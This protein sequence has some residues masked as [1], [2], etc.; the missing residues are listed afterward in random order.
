[1]KGTLKALVLFS[2][3][4]W[5]NCVTWCS[6]YLNKLFQQFYLLDIK[7][8]IK[9]SPSKYTANKGW[10]GF[11]TRYQIPTWIEWTKQSRQS[12]WWLHGDTCI[13]ALERQQTRHWKKS[14]F[15][16]SSFSKLLPCNNRQSLVTFHHHH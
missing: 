3:Y 7:Q 8:Y 15:T 9:I 14:R 4:F 2:Y 10:H 16:T 11:G 1:M 13:V 5:E 6:L 12:D